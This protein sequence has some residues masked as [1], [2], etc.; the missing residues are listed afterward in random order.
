MDAIDKFANLF[1]S[2]QQDEVELVFSQIKN[3]LNLK[4][5]A[6]I[7]AA[8]NLPEFTIVHDSN[9]Q[10]TQSS[11]VIAPPT[12]APLSMLTLTQR[13]DKPISTPISESTTTRTTTT[14]T[15]PQSTNTLKRVR[16]EEP[17][18]SSTQ[19]SQQS[20]SLTNDG[21]DDDDDNDEDSRITSLA[22]VDEDSSCE[23]AQTSAKKAKRSRESR[24]RGGRK[25]IAVRV[26]EAT[27][28]LK[29]KLDEASRVQKSF[30]EWKKINE[31]R[32]EEYNQLEKQHLETL[33]KC[34]TYSLIIAEQTALIRKLKQ[35]LR[36]RQK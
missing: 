7:A 33:T 2:L 27:A 26:A 31:K 18:F 11:G 14:T 21:D 36:E 25:T 17:Y 35:D 34:E 28:D 10:S 1:G 32:I 13:H 30:L 4:R 5:N 20:S 22:A 24:P 19:Q 29:K 12:S 8:T 6:A 15:T 3:S 9:N 16:V 23:S